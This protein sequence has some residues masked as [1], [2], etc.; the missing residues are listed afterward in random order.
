MI[1]IN[2]IITIKSNLGEVYQIFQEED[3][4]NAKEIV[5]AEQGIAAPSSS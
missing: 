4:D 2:I 3:P 1:R 5:D